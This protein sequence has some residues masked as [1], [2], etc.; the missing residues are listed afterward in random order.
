M[1]GPRSLPARQHRGGEGAPAAW[2]WLA[3]KGGFLM[4]PSAAAAFRNA[5]CREEDTEL[6]AEYS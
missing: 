5:V 4:P 3:W 2:P 1:Q 6:H